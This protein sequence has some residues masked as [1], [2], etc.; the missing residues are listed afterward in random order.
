MCLACAWNLLERTRWYTRAGLKE[1]LNCSQ[2]SSVRLRWVSTV[3]FRFTSGAHLAW[4]KQANKWAELSLNSSRLCLCGRTGPTSLQYFSPLRSGQPRADVGPSIPGVLVCIF[5]G[6]CDPPP[7]AWPICG[8]R[9]QH[10]GGGTAGGEGHVPVTSG[11]GEQW[12]MELDGGGAGEPGWCNAVVRMWWRDSFINR[13]CQF[14]V[15]LPF[16]EVLF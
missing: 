10:N 11:G 15:G 2:I 4:K 8:R 3:C 14:L 5:F 1:D 12:A 6:K 16:L 7:I 13:D 9:P